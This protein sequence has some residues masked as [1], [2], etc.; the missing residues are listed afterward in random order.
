MGQSYQFFLNQGFKVVL[1]NNKPLISEYFTAETGPEL[2]FQTKLDPISVQVG[3]YLW[4]GILMS[5]FLSLARFPS[6]VATW[7]SMHSTICHRD[8]SVKFEHNMSTGII[9][10]KLFDR[11]RYPVTVT[12]SKHSCTGIINCTGIFSRQL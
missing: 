6:M 10:N 11:Y 5:P 12:G 1:Q 3:G 7:S 8:S 4:M 9:E 2:L